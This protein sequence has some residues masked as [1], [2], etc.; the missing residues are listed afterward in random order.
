MGRLSEKEDTTS[1]FPRP[2]GLRAELRLNTLKIAQQTL[3]LLQVQ[4][5]IC[6]FNVN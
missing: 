4:L 3:D 2:R 1:I 5:H 6:R